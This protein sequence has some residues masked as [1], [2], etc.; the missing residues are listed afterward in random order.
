MCTLSS[1][2]TVSVFKG[3]QISDNHPHAPLVPPDVF[4]LQEQTHLLSLQER[5]SKYNE[6]LRT[7]K[8]NRAGARKYVNGGLHKS[9]P[10]GV[11]ILDSFEMGAIDLDIEILGDE[12]QEYQANRTRIAIR[13]ASPEKKLLR[14][15]QNVGKELGKLKKGNARAHNDDVGKM[16]GLGDRVGNDGRRVPFALMNSGN[17]ASAVQHSSIAAAAF[18]SKAFPQVLATIRQLEKCAGLCP[19]REMGGRMGVSSTGDQSD[20]L[21]NASHFDINDASQGFSVWAEEKE[22][23]TLNWYF[24]LPNVTVIHEGKTYNGVAIRLAHGVAITWD[25]RLVRHCSSVAK[26]DGGCYGAFWAANRP[27]CGASLIG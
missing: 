1:D 11:L 17:I 15:V 9:L 16:F 26:V 12:P 18:A 2:S 25:G 5:R 10:E 27:L 23:A 14:A 7:S 8:T 3:Q 22:G 6:K 4:G 21:G 19:S 13:N 24:L 20:G